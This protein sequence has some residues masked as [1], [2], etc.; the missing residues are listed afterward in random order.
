VVPVEPD[1]KMR[2][3]LGARSPDL[4]ALTG[5][6]ESVPLPDSSVDAAVAAQAYH[7]FDRDRAHAEIGRIVRSGGVFAAIWNDRDEARPWLADLSR[8]IE[9]DR[10]P[11]GSGA[12][13]ARP[14]LLSF[15]DWFGPTAVARFHHSV[16]HTAESLVSLVAS[17]SYYIT[18]TPG[19]QAEIEAHVRELVA[20]HRD[21]A[22]RAEFPLDYVTTV[23]RAVRV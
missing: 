13:S 8:I 3:R 18:A 21:L 7:W 4:R 12:D 6:A 1:A 5:T 11:D 15:G 20:T 23:Y 22:G 9:G 14:A 17:R 16:P 10:G 2:Q 19:R